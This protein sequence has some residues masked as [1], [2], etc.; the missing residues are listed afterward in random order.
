MSS[1]PSLLRL[2]LS[3]VCFLRDFFPR[4]AFDDC[5]VPVDLA[6]TLP[7][8][9]LKRLRRGHSNAADT[10]LGWIDEV[11]AAAA[12]GSVAVATLD[13][14]QSP[15][16]PR[17]LSELFRLALRPARGP[18]S[19]AQQHR[20]L[21]QFVW[22]VQNLPAGRQ[23]R[24]L[25]MRMVLARPEPPRG[26]FVGAC[27]AEMA[28][29]MWVVGGRY[30]AAGV[31]CG[32]GVEVEMGVVRGGGLRNVDPL[33]LDRVETGLAG[34]AAGTSQ[35]GTTTETEELVGTETAAPLSCECALA[36]SR[37]TTSNALGLVCGVCSR[38][39]HNVCY[40]GITS[41]RGEDT[42]TTCFTCRAGK[43]ASDPRFARHLVCLL[44]SRRAMWGLK[45]APVHSLLRQQPS[46]SAY[47]EVFGFQHPD[48]DRTALALS[49]MI[50]E[51]VLEVLLAEAAGGWRVEADMEGVAGVVPG[52]VVWFRWGTS[53]GRL[54]AEVASRWWDEVAMEPEEARV[55]CLSSSPV[56]GSAGDGTDG[57][58]DDVTANT[59][60]G[61]TD[62][63]EGVVPK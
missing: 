19:A 24:Y 50:R 8:L 61:A 48:T 44:A 55:V 40:R 13:V 45:T 47:V 36:P 31:W 49:H 9:L 42:A 23:H 10:L 43:R 11:V 22:H 32:D 27:D 53:P 12:G 16:D 52:T 7:P 62:G 3:S 33:W 63:E 37:W 25:A 57:A 28:A 35:L 18:A 39:L 14:V 2:A 41:V 46:L 17:V 5:V 34:L 20:A 38:R 1:V 30:V 56:P 26:L 60:L 6:S 58:A 29:D 51:G 4:D 54:Q 59:T 15:T 21:R